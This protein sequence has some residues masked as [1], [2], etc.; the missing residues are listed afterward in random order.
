MNSD[1][2]SVRLESTAFYVL[3]ATVILAPLAFWP[4]P[5]VV[6]DVVKAAI[7]GIGTLIS[8]II[9]GII[10]IQER[11]AVLPPSNIFWTTLCIIA[12]L[13]LSAAASVQAAKSFFGQGFETGT[14]AF[15]AVLFI[16][17]LA[18]YAATVRKS[19]RTILVY[20]A[21]VATYLILFV[22]QALRIAFGPGFMTLSILGTRTASVL[23]GWYN[24]GTFSLVIAL[25]SLV[26]VI[27]LPLSRGMKLAYVVLGVISFVSAA[28]INDPRAWLA[29]FATT[30]ALLVYFFVNRRPNGSGIRGVLS[31][32]AWIPLIACLVVFVFVWRGPAIAG[33]AINRANIG[34]SELSLPWQMTLDVTAG[35]IKNSPLFGVG[36]NHFI[37]AFFANKPETIN[38]TAAWN[39]EFP[40]GFAYL[41]T[42]LVTQGLLGGI[43]WTLFLV[44]FGIAAVKTLKRLPQD[45]SSSF[46]V[47]S[48][49]FISIFLWLMLLLSVPSPAM[50]FI[51]FV[52]TGIFFGSAVSAGC[53][54]PL[55][56]LPQP[57]TRLARMFTPALIVVIVLGG[58]M[59]LTTVRKTVA[60]SYFG[61]G[62]KELTVTGNAS[63]ADADFRKALMFDTSDVFFQGRAEAAL[64][65]ANAI[66]NN[67]SH[68]GSAS[69]SQAMLAQVTGLVNQA[70]GDAQTAIAYDPSNYYNYISAA[71]VS[72]IAS[73]LK[74]DNAY[75]SAVTSYTKAIGLNPGNPSIYLSL[76]RLQAS[77]AKYDDAIRTLGAALRVKNNYLDGVFLLSQ[78]YAAQGDLGNAIIA[79]Q[80]A[81]QLNPQNPLL[82]FQLGLLEYNSKNYT[83]AAGALAAAVKIQPDYA[84]AEYFL[85]LSDARLGN[86]SDAVAQFSALAHSNPDNQEVALILANLQAGKPI[87]ADTQ[88]AVT[89]PEK[90]PT[91]PVKE[92]QR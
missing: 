56:L 34:Y 32:I 82:Y 78:V 80:V 8:A 23:G 44:F 40:S 62:V 53:L 50:L 86:T 35:S 69:S 57:Q 87:F 22:F 16:A 81:T 55:T 52:I 24:F 83:A 61:S 9:Y 45:P 72:E 48:S 26:A 92:K 59:L 18:A 73:G 39:V 42:F 66:G 12:S 6:L 88:A 4:S 13:V 5:Y 64:A 30:V 38:P 11:K 47:L 51:T 1:T 33:P 25:L 31:R 60:L 71:R 37:Q 17:A 14:V 15:V 90:R 68:A 43:L 79:S 54:V 49:L 65:E 85:G 58:L 28:L 7:I 2:P 27:R 3:L 74:M 46:I 89:P 67:I 84:N 70:Y 63:Q 10:A 41:P 21:L 20:A 76:A 77:Q 75:D 91:L 29:A 19:E 36:P